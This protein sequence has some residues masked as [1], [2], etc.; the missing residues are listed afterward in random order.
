MSK[1]S[2]ALDKAKKERQDSQPPAA[3]SSPEQSRQESPRPG[4]VRTRVQNPRQEILEQNRIISA[5]QDQSILDTY[6]LLRTQILQKTRDK[7]W[8]T[9]M[10]TSPRAGEGKTTTALNLALSIAREAMQT[11]LVVDTNLRSPKLDK[12][13]D[14]QCS[15]GLTDYLLDSSGVSELLVNPNLDKFVLLPAGRAL[16]G[17]TDILSSPRMQELVNELKN[18]YPDR[19]VLFDC[20]HLLNMPDSLLFSSYVDAV[21]LVVEAGKTSREDIDHSLQLLEGKNI[22]GLVLNKGAQA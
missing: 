3:E 1:L 6:N 7:G 5:I 19:Y 22:L 18:R 14:L 17:S 9:I 16:S 2:K 20:P 8:N 11:A 12:L 10:I 15:K 21:I 4:S 13:L